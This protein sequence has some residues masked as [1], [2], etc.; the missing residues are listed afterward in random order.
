MTTTTQPTTSTRITFAGEDLYLLAEHA[1]WWPRTST[2]I[3]ADL[4][5]G[6]D[7][8]FRAGGL[9]LPSGVLDA[10]LQ[11]LRKLSDQHRPERIL[12]LGDLIHA[13]ASLTPEVIDTVTAWRSTE[14]A[15]CI[16]VEGNHDRH[17]PTLPEAWK[18]ERVGS[19]F[20][21]GPLH[22]VHDPAH[23]PDA[24]CLCGHLHPSVNFRRGLRNGRLPCFQIG[25]SLGVLPA[26]SEFTGAGRLHPLPTQRIFPIMGG[27]CFEWESLPA[28]VR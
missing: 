10:D 14:A 21:D 3:V 16:L 28:T 17:A 19:A 2:L 11:R 13:R 6:K 22:F 9:P 5:W 1:V 27:L 15:R 8:A 26:F 12:I 24:P 7:A 20:S 18:I 23:A 25:A 4:H